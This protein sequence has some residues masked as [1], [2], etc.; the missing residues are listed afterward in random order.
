MSGRHSA[1]IT[2]PC[3][4]RE[5]DQRASEGEGEL[6]WVRAERNHC[7]EARSG[8]LRGLSTRQKGNSRNRAWHGIPKH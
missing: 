6:P 2:E 5:V 8:L 1:R 7:R 3:A 4:Q